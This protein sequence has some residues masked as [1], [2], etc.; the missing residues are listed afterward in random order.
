MYTLIYVRFKIDVVLKG[1]YLNQCVGVVETVIGR[2][3]NSEWI[4]AGGCRAHGGA[5]ARIR[6][7]I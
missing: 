1:L 5:T 2:W 7:S 4:L 6:Q 3:D